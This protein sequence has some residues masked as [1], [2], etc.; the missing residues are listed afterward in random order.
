MMKR[1]CILLVVALMIL[2]CDQSFNPK[3]EFE[4]TL[5]IYAVFSNASDTVLIRVNHSY[6]PSGFDPF[7]LTVDPTVG[8]GSVQLSRNDTLY[9]VRDTLIT[10]TD[11]SRYQSDIQA[12]VAAP[13]PVRFGDRFALT[14]SSPSYGSFSATTIIPGA[15]EI[16]TIH[17]FELDRAT[18]MKSDTLFTSIRISPATAGYFFRAYLEYDLI[19]G[20]DTTVNRIEVPAFYGSYDGIIASHPRYHVLHRRLSPPSSGGWELYEDDFFLVNSFLRTAD[21]LHAQ[22]QTALIRRAV[23]VLNQVEPGFYNYYNIVN[24][25][26]DGRSIR[27]D[28]PGF[29][30]FA[31]GEGIFGA[32]TVEEAFHDLPFKLYNE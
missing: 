22:L 26:R 32:F 15:G 3:G 8:D 2:S 19:S 11:K 1:I 17:F 20:A 30:T 24:G 27:I 5:A 28:E 21:I 29:T 25:F 4:R 7:E 23:F 16:S 14:V 18:R 9:A 10:R 6:D 12:Y 31:G 13:V